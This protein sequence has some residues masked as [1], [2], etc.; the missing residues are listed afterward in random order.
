MIL[1]SFIHLL[2]YILYNYYT[3]VFYNTNPANERLAFYLYKKLNG[4][5][6]YLS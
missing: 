3:L 6:L 5:N 4:K 2:Y 1:L